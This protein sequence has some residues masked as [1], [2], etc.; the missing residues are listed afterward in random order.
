MDIR[1]LMMSYRSI[2]DK[3]PDYYKQSAFLVDEFKINH[4]SYLRVYCESHFTAEPEI[5]DLQ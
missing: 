1:W 3:T 5:Q 4:I 2:L